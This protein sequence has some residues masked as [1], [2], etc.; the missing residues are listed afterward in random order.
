MR[1]PAVI[2]S[3]Y[4]PAGSVLRP[5]QDGPPFDHTS[6]I[7]TLN[8]LFDLG[9][10]L[11][12]RAAA[13]P[14]LLSTLRLQ[15]PDNA[16]PARIDANAA[17]ATRQETRALHRLPDNGH[18]RR[19]RHPAALVPALAAQAAAHTHWAKHKVQRRR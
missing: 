6:I 14:D 13:A 1:V 7:A 5:P 17:R 16:G 3:P 9:E 4:V 8:A 10:P 18:Q 2:V 12:P 15:R 19:M 11:S